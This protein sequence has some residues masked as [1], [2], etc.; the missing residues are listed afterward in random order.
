VTKKIRV[1]QSSLAK[2]GFVADDTGH[3]I[4]YRFFIGGKRTDVYT[5]FSHGDVEIHGGRI[6]QT[7]K[8]LR[9][10][11]DKFLELIDCHMDESA[12]TKLLLDGGH[13][14]LP[15]FLR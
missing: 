1:I 5:F 10:D 9:L 8:Q 13:I 14:E 12:Y 6:N 7:A 4:Y 2:K 11:K 15:E 3:H